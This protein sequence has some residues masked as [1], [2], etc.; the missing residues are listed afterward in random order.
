MSAAMKA[1]FSMSGLVVAAVVAFGANTVPNSAEAQVVAN[2]VRCRGCV[3]KRDIGKKQIVSK[4]IKDGRVKAKDLH[5]NAKPG[6]VSASEFVNYPGTVIAPGATVVLREAT[7]DLPG[8][9]AV[10]A[11]ASA[12]IVG[13]NLALCQVDTDTD[14]I[15]LGDLFAIGSGGTDVSYTAATNRVFEA[16]AGPLTVYWK[17][18]ATAGVSG[19]LNPSLSLLYVPGVQSLVAA[20]APADGAASNAAALELF[21]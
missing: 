18:T 9:G 11:I 6:A 12:A 21:K 5:K 1:I 20:D 17:C 13:S 16:P 3:G 8:P 19:A 2:D 10:L 4:H 14:P 7:I 15:G